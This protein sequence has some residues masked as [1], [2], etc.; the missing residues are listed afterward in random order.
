MAT[1]TLRDHRDLWT[2]T[3]II[4]TGALVSSCDGKSVESAKAALTAAG[5]QTGAPPTAV[6]IMTSS[7]TPSAGSASS[8]GG[9]MGGAP[10]AAPPPAAAP[11]STPAAPISPPATQTPT[12][13]S[14]GSATPPPTT[15]SSPQPPPVTVN[16]STQYHLTFDDEFNA[17]TS[18]RW[19]TSDFW[20]MRNNGGD[21]QAQ[22]FADPIYVPQGDTRSP[23]NA[24]QVSNNVLSIIAKPTPPNTYSG[25]S[26]L[27]YV[28]GQL[29]S[30]HLFTQRYGYYE[31]RAKL[32][33][34]KGLWSRF[35][36]LTDDGVWP[37]EY[38][39]FEVLGKE[40][41]QVHQ[42]THYRDSNNVNQAPGATYTGILPTDGQFHTYGFLWT[43]TG[44]SWYVDQQLT[45]TQVNR[46]TIPM[47]VLIDLAVG[48][49]PG[50][51]WPGNPDGKTPWPAGMQIDYYRVYSNDPSLPSVSPDPGYVASTLPNGLTVV[52]APTVGP[53]PPG[54]LVTGIGAPTLRGSATWNPT[55]GE[56]MVKGA[57]YGNQEEFAG[58]P[59]SAD[60]AVSATVTS[61]TRINGND[62]RGGVAIRSSTDSN[63]PEISLVYSTSANS[64]TNRTR[65]V[66]ISRGSLPTTELASTN[67][68][69]API[70]LRL[71]RSGNVF[72]GSYSADGGNTWVVVGT[73][74]N[75]Q[76][77]GAALAGLVVGGNQNNYLR[78]SRGLFT[79][80][81]VVGN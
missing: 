62:D 2:A 31:L 22:W 75:T 64:P 79:T 5:T 7:S 20:G 45:L 19:Q 52:P 13:S 44:V 16:P 74:Q 41:G 38:D 1:Q 68:T 81:T 9:G 54:W 67:V 66:L 49:D 51:L 14:G 18:S 24:F 29:T 69:G 35:W 46:V 76:L 72:T 71:T 42:T 37:G 8:P 36:L 60:G 40:T 33:P 3:A 43:A 58:R 10:S 57:G 65:V 78:L 34:G 28:S 77:T 21:Y 30:A 4:A 50:N 27:P 55:N 12:G 80:V 25:P 6:G 39:I 61:L 59:L 32:P 63:A 47:Y 26:N 23:Y 48:N 15:P 56:W 70:T 11:T 17:F 73:T 53:L